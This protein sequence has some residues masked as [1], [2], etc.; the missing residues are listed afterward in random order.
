MPHKLARNQLLDGHIEWNRCRR[1]PLAAHVTQETQRHVVVLVDLHECEGAHPLA[2]VDESALLLDS[3]LRVVFESDAALGHVPLVADLVVLLDLRPLVG[4]P[5]ARQSSL[6]VSDVCEVLVIIRKCLHLHLL[7]HLVPL[8]LPA[9]DPTTPLQLIDF[10]V[11]L[12]HPLG[13]PQLDR[14]I[15]Q[16]VISTDTLRPLHLSLVVERRLLGLP[17]LPQLTYDLIALDLQLTLGPLNRV[18]QLLGVAHGVLEPLSDCEV[19]PS[20][21]VCPVGQ[22]TLHLIRIHHV[23]LRISVVGE[24]VGMRRH[25]QSG[26]LVELPQSLPGL[27]VPWVG[28]RVIVLRVRLVRNVRLVIARQILGE[29]GVHV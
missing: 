18:A 14:L 29:E 25:D 21:P 13:Q 2:P 20:C 6:D 9:A 17:L 3:Q 12:P 28:Q 1:P 5:A 16:D 19:G 26:R 15:R 7:S 23:D 24:G 8:V 27:V 10:L 11:N 4:R 22:L